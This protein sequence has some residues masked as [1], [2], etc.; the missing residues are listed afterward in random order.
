MVSTISR[1][2]PTLFLSVGTL[3]RIHVVR[4]EIPA[5]PQ[6]RRYRASSRCVQSTRPKLFV[7]RVAPFI[8]SCKLASVLMATIT[9]S[10]Y[11][12][13]SSRQGRSLL[14]PESRYQPNG[15]PFVVVGFVVIC[16]TAFVGRNYIISKKVKLTLMSPKNARYKKSVGFEVLTAVVMKSSIFWDIMPCSPLEISRRFGGIYRLH[17]QGRIINRARNQRESRWHSLPP[18]FTLVSCSAYSS[19]MPV[20]FQQ[21]TRRFIPEDVTLQNYHTSGWSYFIWRR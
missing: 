17:L 20:D 18:A 1:Y 8:V 13:V 16:S 14:Y 5:T 4:G 6:N 15:T 7:K 19:E 10:C 9:N 11:K 12:Q 2:G 21:T 3:K